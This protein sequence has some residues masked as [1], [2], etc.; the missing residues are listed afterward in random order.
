M[1]VTPELL[2]QIPMF[3]DLHEAELAEIMG[4]F[5]E[6]SIEAG[7]TL[8]VE[9][10]AAT[11]ACFLIDGELEALKALPGGGAAQ[12]GV[13]G[14]GSMIGEMALV[15]GGTRSA[16][17]RAM[18]QS[19]ILTVSYYFFHAALDQM[20][21]PAFK[22]LRSV[23][24]SLTTRLEGLQRRIL[25]QWD[26]EAPSRPSYEPVPER[27]LPE[28]SPDRTHSFDYRPFLPIIPFFANFTESEIDRVV[29][30][31][32]V[33]ELPRGD[34]LYREGAP[35]ESCYILVRGAI[36][37]SVI[38]DR[39]YQLSI[40]GPGRLCGAN[41]LIAETL[42][43]SDARVRSAAL[44]LSFDKSAYRNLYLGA[45]TECLKFQ[46]MVSVNQLQELKT[47]DNLLT[48]LVSQ[49]YVLEGARNRG[50]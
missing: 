20:S 46:S 44:L 6:A 9:G 43:N 30:H 29:A 42:R 4:C 22:I 24:Y 19:K 45:T 40:L 27:A 26:C 34:F 50:L 23:I 32:K 2:K 12:V 25:E 18:T 35:V 49:D 7:E 33:L 16:T 36:E 5:T 28:E 1:T 17:V 13:I 3:N 15:A 39:R 8:Y 11:S 31:A 47:A 10:D 21:A 38:R 37:I 41:S 14:P 48:T